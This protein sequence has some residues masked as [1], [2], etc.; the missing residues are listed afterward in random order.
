M[1]LGG[2]GEIILDSSVQE[3]ITD[4]ARHVCQE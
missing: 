4:I 2:I 1:K 3:D